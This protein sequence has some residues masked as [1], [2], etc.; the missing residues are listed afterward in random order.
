H[1]RIGAEPAGHRDRH[2]RSGRR[3]V[4]E[5]A[6]DIVSPA[7]TVPT[8]G[9]A[10][11]VQAADAHVLEQC[12]GADG[13]RRK[14]LAEDALAELPLAVPPPAPGVLRQVDAAA[15]RLSG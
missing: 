11:G 10:A 1:Q 8:D 9:D 3:S 12:G 2:R 15:V 14:G 13:A 7:Q 6:G 4:A 5:L